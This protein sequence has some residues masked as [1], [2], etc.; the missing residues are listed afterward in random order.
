MEYNEPLD[1]EELALFKQLLKRYLNVACPEC[2]CSDLEDRHILT[3]TEC[4]TILGDLR[5]I[6]N[7]ETGLY[8]IV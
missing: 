8:Q 5:T 2:E 7:D 4:G 6:I 3:C 1:M